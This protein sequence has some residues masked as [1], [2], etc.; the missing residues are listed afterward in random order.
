MSAGR[1]ILHGEANASAVEPVHFY[2]IW[3]YPEREGIEPSYEQ[4]AFPDDGERNQWRLVVSP[5]GRGGSLRIH[6][7]ASIH[8][9][10]LDEGQSLSQPIEEGRAAWLQVLRGS[11]SLGGQT[12]KA[13]DGAA[14]ADESSINL[15]ASGPSELMLFD[16]A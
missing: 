10:T 3:L 1:G 16:L 11:V 15:R 13:G 9:A 2:Q 4:K 14:I 8:L 12:L 5:D 6:Q 7:D